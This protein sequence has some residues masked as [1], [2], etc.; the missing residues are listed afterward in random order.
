MRARAR[1]HAGM[2]ARS[3]LSPLAVALAGREYVLHRLSV[4]A[5]VLVVVAPAALGR[6]QPRGPAVAAGELAASGLE[7][8]A[9]D[10]HLDA[11]RESR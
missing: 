3:T 8:Q 5:A 11:A 9:G 2:R 7:S 1:A 10:A 4:W 6:R